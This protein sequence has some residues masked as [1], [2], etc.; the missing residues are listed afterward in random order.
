T[1]AAF[2]TAHFAPDASAV[3]PAGEGAWSRAFSFESEG[4]QLIARF[5]FHAD[6]FEKDRRSVAFRR[7]GLPVP[8]V[9]AIGAAFDGYFAVSERVRG[10][11]LESLPPAAWRTT[12][13]SL[14]DALEALRQ[15]D[16]GGT[17]GYGE[18]SGSGDATYASWRDYLLAIGEDTPGRRT[19]GWREKLATHPDGPDAF[20]WGLALLREVAGDSAPRSLIHAD[21]MNRNVLVDGGRISG[22]FDWG[23]AA[24]GD[25]LYDLAWFEFW[26]PWHP[27]LDVPLLRA[28]LESRW[29][30]VGYDPRNVDSPLLACHLHIGLAHLAYNAHLGD[31]ESLAATAERMR[32]LAG[33]P[34]Y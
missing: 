11:V 26:A 28:A 6:D 33:N 9:L 14:V 13:P 7:P 19:H 10:E 25:H 15:A 30:N 12:V 22:V 17:A 31:W 4:R 20:A 5:G 8:R 2:L 21:L 23:C 24:Y 16:I 1:A 32:H 34:R 27:N 29:R 18:W 3:A